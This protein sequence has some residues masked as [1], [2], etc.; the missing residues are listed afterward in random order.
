M[1]ENFKV[2]EIHQKV[3]IPN[4]TPDEVYKAFLSSKQHSDFTG[5]KA[6]CSARKGSK[7]TA[8]DGYISGRNLEL[9]K[10]KKIVQEWQTSE[11]PEGYGPST[12]KIILKKVGGE[13][14]L[15]FAQTNVPS[16]Q[17]K[18]YE[19]G[20]FDSYWNPLKKYFAKSQASEKVKDG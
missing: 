9:I 13:T 8:W 18:E 17:V 7:F 15:S 20:W 6:T 1:R 5:S 16:S 12:L 4:A 11:W 10:G 19:K 3:L 2:S 14:E